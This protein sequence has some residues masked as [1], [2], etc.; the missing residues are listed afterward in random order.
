MYFCIFTIK[1]LIGTI[2]AAIL[3][4]IFYIFRA[5]LIDSEGANQH[6][7]RHLQGTPLI[8]FSEDPVND[9]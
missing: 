7:A 9:H 6:N 2:G 3:E 8:A 4:K 5:S 1:S